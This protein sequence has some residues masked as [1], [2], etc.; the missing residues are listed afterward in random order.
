MNVV[1]GQQPSTY[2]SDQEKM[3]LSIGSNVQSAEKNLMAAYAL[4]EG[5]SDD[6]KNA[7]TT[8]AQ[9]LGLTGKDVTDATP[10]SLQLIAE[11]RFQQSTQ[12][13]SLFSNLMDKI[14]QMKQRVISK[15]SN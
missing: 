3:A 12:V 7:I 14:D 4:K 6:A 13:F 10:R 11:Q 1:N 15:M 8:L 9:Q 5:T 2:L